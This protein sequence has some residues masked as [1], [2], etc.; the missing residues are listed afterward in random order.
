MDENFWIGVACAHIP[1]VLWVVLKVGVEFFASRAEADGHEDA[2]D[3]FWRRVRE[4]I[5]GTNPF[6]RG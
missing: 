3:I 5:T 6:K 4:I 2:N 1:T